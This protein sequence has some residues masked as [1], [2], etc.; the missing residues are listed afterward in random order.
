MRW[1]AP[2]IKYNRNDENLQTFHQVDRA[3]MQASKRAYIKEQKYYFFSTK[4]KEKEP[5]ICCR[6]N[7]DFWR[8]MDIFFHP[9]IGTKGNEFFP[10]KHIEK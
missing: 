8:R 3:G 5:L 9:L 7:N 2:V 10:S 1:H 4:C 6:H